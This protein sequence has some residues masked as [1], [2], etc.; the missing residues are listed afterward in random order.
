MKKNLEVALA[1]KHCLEQ[2]SD[3]AH[4]MDMTELGDLIGLA[5]LAAEDAAN[6]LVLP[7]H[8]NVHDGSEVLQ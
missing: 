2:L 3:E 5:A 8:R 1:I 6:T 7:Y 4:A